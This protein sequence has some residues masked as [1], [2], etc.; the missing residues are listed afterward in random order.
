MSGIAAD[1]NTGTTGTGGDVRVTAGTLS[2]T[3]KGE[4]ASS[5]FGA[6]RGGSVSVAVAGRLEID[7]ASSRALGLTGITSEA[8][9]G[10]SGSAGDVFV[11]AGSL[12]ILDNGEISSATFGTENAGTVSV[13]ARA[14]SLASGGE[15]ASGSEAGSSGDAGNVII[16]AGSLGISDGLISSGLLAA[17][18]GVPASA[19]RRA[20][21]ITVEVSGLLTIV[22]SGSAA[23]AGIA[24]DADPGTTGN[25]GDVHVT[26]AAL[27][28]VDNGEIGSGTFGAGTGGTVFVAVSGRLK[29]NGARSDPKFVTGIAT[30]AN[31]GSTNKAGDVFVRAGGLTILDGGAITS[32]AVGASEQG[33]AATGNAGK[34]A[35]LVA[36]ELS[37]QG[38]QIATTTDPGTSGAAGSVEVT[39]G[40]V[41]IADGGEIVSTTAGTGAGGSVTVTTRG[42]LLLDGNGIPGTEIAASATG[43]QSGGAGAV[44][45]TAGSLTIESGAEIASSTAGPGAGGQVEVVVGSG[46]VLAGAGSQI[47][48]QSIGSGNAGSLEVTAGQ[49]S[50]ADGAAIVSTSAGTGAGGSVTVTTRGTLLLDGGGV[51]GSEIAASATGPQSGPAGTVAVTAGSLTIKG[52]AEIASTT[53]G[54]GTGGDV[55]LDVSSDLVLVGP[56]P[57]ITAQSSAGGDAGAIAIAADRLLLN[58]G[59]AISTEAATSTANG[60]NIGMSLR[61]MLYLTDGE[62]TTSVQGVTGNGG[63]ITIASPFVILSGSDVIAQAV[64]GHGGNI[65]IDAGQYIPSADSIVSASSAFGV[66]GNVVISGPRV[67]LNGTLVVLSSELLSAVAVTRASCAARAPGPQSSLVE[68]GRGGLPEDPNASLPALYLAGRDLRLDPRVAPRRAEAEGDLPSTLEI[69]VA[70]R[71]RRWRVPRPRQ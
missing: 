32:S 27:S 9:P 23:L 68:A 56:G 24:T 51:P 38:G 14:I 3:D 7:G 50:V 52:G 46:V 48:A 2:V 65:M 19:G 13:T 59:A 62:I 35:V 34:V 36:G 37:I 21:N 6:G 39:A 66:S 54:G 40:Q 16:K 22:G 29:I 28:I 41:S 64:E 5:T 55:I 47:T 25:A 17:F 58:G 44:A 43:P 61:E 10:S 60:G 30:Q 49:I 53:A 8:N 67:D 42:A 45:V 4:I 20:G 31:Q 12:S 63:N 1:A 26:A 33:P 69:A 15:I 70:L 11:R 57:Q 71:L 18:N